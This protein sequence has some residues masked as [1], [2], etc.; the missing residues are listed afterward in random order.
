MNLKVVQILFL[1]DVLLY[2]TIRAP[3]FKRAFLIGHL[4]VVFCNIINLAPV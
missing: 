3:V 1:F 2:V 4:H